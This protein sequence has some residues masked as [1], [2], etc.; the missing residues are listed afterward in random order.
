MFMFSR[1]TDCCLMS[2]EATSPL[3]LVYDLIGGCANFGY[4]RS[5]IYEVSFIKYY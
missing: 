2:R 4:L 3:F 5:S 1:Q